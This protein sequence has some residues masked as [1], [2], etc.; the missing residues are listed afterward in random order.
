M[1][2]DVLTCTGSNQLEGMTIVPPGRTRAIASSRA[3]WLP[4]HSMTTSYSSAS[5]ESCA[6]FLACLELRR[7][8]RDEV[9]LGAVMARDRGEREPDA[10]AADDED[11]IGRLVSVEPGL[12]RR[13]ERDRD[14]FDERRHVR[15]DF[16][17][18]RHQ[19]TAVDDHFFC[20]PAI[21]EDPVHA[22]VRLGAEMVAPGQAHGARAARGVRLHGD[23]RLSSSTP[24]NSWPSVAGKFHF[25]IFRSEPQ[26]PADRTWIRTGSDA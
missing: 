15:T 12:V 1:S 10:A 9:D 24:A 13:V 22:V 23:Q 21:G 2:R 4:A 14:R 16:R 5:D 17:R 18:K 6:E 26:M 19:T 11:A 25:S 3:D 20:E 7:V 8:A